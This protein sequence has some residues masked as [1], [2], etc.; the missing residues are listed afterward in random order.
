MVMM[1]YVDRTAAVMV[2]CLAVRLMYVT[3]HLPIEIAVQVV[4]CPRNVSGT[5]TMS[6]GGAIHQKNQRTPNR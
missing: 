4:T 6:V 1:V 2:I 3:A 5:A